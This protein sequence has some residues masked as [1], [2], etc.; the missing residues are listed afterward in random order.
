MRLAQPFDPIEPGEIDSFVFDFTPD[1][2]AATIASTSWTCAHAPYQTVIDPSPQSHIL[3]SVTATQIQFRSS[4]D[5]NVRSQIG[6]FSVGMVG[7]FPASVT[8][9]VYILE[10][11]A[12]VSDGRV[13]KL[14]STVTVKIPG[15]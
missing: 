13:L 6:A 10:A 12:N 2:G 5:G 11:T 3:S 4:I 9:A 8:G 15:P 1:I 7:G 14:N